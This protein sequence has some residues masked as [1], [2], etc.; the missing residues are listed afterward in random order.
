MTE[1]KRYSATLADLPEDERSLYVD[2]DNRKRLAYVMATGYTPDD[3][4]PRVKFG[5]TVHEGPIAE[6]VYDLREIVFRLLASYMQTDAGLAEADRRAGAAERRLEHYREDEIKQ[7]AWR[8]E[9]KQLVGLTHN[10]SFDKAWDLTYAAWK[11]APELQARADQAAETAAAFSEGDLS[12]VYLKRAGP[13][14]AKGG[15]ELVLQSSGAIFMVEAMAEMLK[16]ADAPN[17]L[18]FEMTH[19]ELGPLSFSVQREAPDADT[20]TKKLTRMREAL[21]PFADFAFENVDLET[22]LWG[23]NGADTDRIHHHFGAAAFKA[24]HDAVHLAALSTPKAE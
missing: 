22:G 21:I 2:P 19:P 12:K 17:F 16:G 18:S 6:L 7:N 20:P 13:D 3:G 10:D 23:G 9:R 1:A 5:D 11:A 8:A 24:A 4:P 15:F 14:Y